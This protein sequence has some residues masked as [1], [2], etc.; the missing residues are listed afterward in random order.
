MT[1]APKSKSLGDCQ[2]DAVTIYSLVRGLNVLLD[3]WGTDVDAREAFY[4]LIE[5]LK[6][7][8]EQHAD[9]LDRITGREVAQ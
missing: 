7:R 4:A 5:V 1:D 3:G 2:H 6:E 8:A 9:D